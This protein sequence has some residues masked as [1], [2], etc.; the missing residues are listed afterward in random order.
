MIYGV[1]LLDNRRNYR[2]WIFNDEWLMNKVFQG[3]I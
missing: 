1:L 2:S 3:M